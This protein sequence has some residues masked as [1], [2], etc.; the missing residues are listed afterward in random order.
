MILV[1]KD[2]VTVTKTFSWAP[3]LLTVTLHDQS[4]Y[5]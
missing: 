4:N 3:T 2:T 1:L 5:N